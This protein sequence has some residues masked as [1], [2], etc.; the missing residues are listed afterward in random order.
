MNKCLFSF[1]YKQRRHVSHR[2]F[3]NRFW[4][5]CKPYKKAY[6]VP[7][8]L[9]HC[10]KYNSNFPCGFRIK[11]PANFGLLCL[12]FVFCTCM[13]KNI[14]FML[15]S[16]NEQ[17]THGWGLSYC[18][19]IYCWSELYSIIYKSDSP[20]SLLWANRQAQKVILFERPYWP[21]ITR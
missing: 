7:R 10:Y 4:S 18:N 21:L 19:S 15:S 17:E 12:I 9:V 2:D 20:D 1:V 3:F 5:V 13:E 6:I 11:I 16:Q 8:A 14:L